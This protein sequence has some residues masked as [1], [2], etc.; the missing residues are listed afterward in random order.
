MR[1]FS[2]A[3]LIVACAS[4]L[5]PGNA[6]AGGYEYPDHGTLALGR[7]GAFTA[8]ADDPS[9]I[10]YNPGGLGRLE[11]THILLGGN[12][13]FEQVS[14]Q[15]QVWD[16]RTLS[17]SYQYPDDPTSRM[18]EIRSDDPPFLSPLGGLATDLSILRPY[19][20]VLLVGAYGPH[21]HP[22]RTYPRYCVKGTNPCEPTD[23]SKTGIPSPARYDTTLV[24]VF[25]VYPSIGLAWQPIPQ[26]SIGAVFQTAYAQFAFHSVAS[27]QLGKAATP[28]EAEN[29]NND[30]DIHVESSDPF[31][32]TGIIGVHAAP[33]PFLELGVS[34]RIGFTLNFEGEVQSSTTL[35]L[36][37]KLVKPNPGAIHISL[38]LP[39]V[40]RT[41]LRWIVRDGRDRELLDVE[42]DF[43]WE[44]NS[45]VE[46]FE[47]TPEPTFNGKPIEG[48]SLWHRWEDSYSLRL[49]GSYQVHDVIPTGLLR[50]SLG[51]FYEPS[52]MPEAFTRLDFVPLD[53]W[54]LAAGVAA[55]YRWF[56]LGIS[57]AHVFHMDRTV[58]NS[59]VTQI[60]P[61]DASYGVVIG[62]GTYKVDLDL[63]SIGLKAVF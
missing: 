4:L 51:G 58:T 42:L 37:E 1:R 48:L 25:V 21:V 63:L 24:D 45:Q 56:E 32:P 31:T 46:V 15:R 13:Q 62:N 33:F 29:K 49:G 10:L 57:Y 26:L 43:N 9:A 14:F 55:S 18:P 60:T 16:P 44:S 27:A 19:N 50:I 20:L 6:R 54:G 8:R 59:Q 11:G 28:A 47:V 61:L 30:V 12:V 5:G 53:R 34:V 39:W 7:G 3:P 22:A 23:D 41:G 35:G 17:W 38:N 40:V 36:L 2:V 52:P